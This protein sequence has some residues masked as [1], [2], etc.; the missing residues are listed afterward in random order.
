MGASKS[1]MMFGVTANQKRLLDV[2]TRLINI[3]GVLLTIT[4]CSKQITTINVNDRQLWHH[5]FDFRAK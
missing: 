2:S 4:D 1:S 5:S 3:N